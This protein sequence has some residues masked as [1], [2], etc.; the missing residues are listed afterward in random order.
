MCIRDSLINRFYDV[1]KGRVF[2]DGID[3]RD[4]RKDDLRRSLGI[5]LQDTHLFS[6][7]IADNI[8]FGKLDATQ[9]VSYTH[10]LY[11]VRK[12]WLPAAEAERI[13]SVLKALGLPVFHPL[14]SRRTRCV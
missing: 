2:Y 13:V 3:V 9:A 11:S 10:L 5:V 12:G 8:R 14:L 7:T 1:H 6:G 4:I